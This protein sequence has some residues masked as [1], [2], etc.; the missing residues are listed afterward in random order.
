MVV[1]PFVLSLVGIGF[2]SRGI[3][4]GL[5][6]ATHHP[7]RAEEVGVAFGSTTLL[8]LLAPP[9]ILLAVGSAL[10]LAG[11]RRRGQGS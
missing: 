11:D 7:E 9:G 8:A 6:G 5:R 4:G 1:V 10:A 3:S 2:A